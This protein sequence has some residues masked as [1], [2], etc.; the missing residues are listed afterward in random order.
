VPTA[1]APLLTRA[2]LN[3]ALLARQH[4]LARVAGRALDLV[5]H[6]V[7]LQAQNPPSPY[8]ALWSRVEGF[9]H[10]DLGA[11]LESRRAARIAVMRGTIHLVTAADA[12]VLP[13]LTAAL[14]ARDLRTSS[15]HGAGLRQLDL[16]ELTEAARA[17]VEESPRTTTELG[18]LLAER[19]P[20]V[21]PTTLAYGARGTLPLVQVLPRGVWRQSG[22]T[23]WTTA[24]AWFGPVAVDSA[25]DLA[26]PDVRAAELE[27]L[28]LRFIAAFGPASVA[29]VQQWSGIAG[30]RSVVDRLRDRLVAFRAEPGPGSASGRELFDLPDA[31]RPSPEVDAPVRF[32]PDLDN[33]LLAHAD[34]TR[35]VS[36]EHR[37]RLTSANGVLPGTFLAGGRVAG[38]WSVTRER[39]DPGQA[40][41]RRELATLEL[42]P[43]EALDPATSRAVTA[44]GEGL[45]RFV[46]DDAA[47]HRVRVVPP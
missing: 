31:P 5:D 33:L 8:T 27:R 38:T 32:L 10:D 43:F 23:T 47:D 44:E 14:Y 34:R 13:G 35:V 17:L 3:R 16:T 1:D 30:L 21:A 37:R 2:A 39:R 45:V 22:A 7:G 42:R 24:D 40:R 18:R 36:E 46:A 29:D 12:L 4:L 6:L 26:D 41:G 15:Q 11:A 20:D 19:W 28:V 25:P 9:R